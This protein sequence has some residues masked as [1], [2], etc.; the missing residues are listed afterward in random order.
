MAGVSTD[1][2]VG[3]AVGLALG[4]LFGALIA[5][6]LASRRRALAIAEEQ[7]CLQAALDP[8]REEFVALERRLGE[9]RAADG[10]ENSALREQLSH[11]LRRVGELVQRVGADAQGLR[12]A[13]QGNVNLRG[14][15]G[16]AI[17]EQ[18]FQNSGLRRGVHYETQ[19]TLKPDASGELRDMRRPDAIVRQ[20]DGSVVVI[21]S[22][23]LFPDYARYVEAETAETRAA[24]LQAHVRA[25]RS[26][27][28]D[29][30]SRHYERRVEGSVEFVLMFLPV[31]GAYQ[32]AIAAEPGLVTE[33]LER[34]VLPVGPSAL[35]VML[36]LIQR[37]WR[38]GEQE[39]NAERIL[40]AARILAERTLAF[41]T[42]LEQVGA[43]LGKASAAYATAFRR[44]TATE[45][46]SRSVAAS[47]QVLQRLRSEE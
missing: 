25:F 29:L 18:L 26:T 43:A 5:L 33:S 9:V 37:L 39:R 17:L 47:R 31:E 21:D 28:R 16:E 32:S 45:P 19:V 42:D 4:V 20:P 46:G 15:W 2:L 36:T 34:N 12:H 10:A 13:L 22:K 44:L 38:R 8:V 24:A 11:D 41:Q 7:A 6:L 27:M 35:I 40:E 14:K 3:L 30:A 1:L 23:T